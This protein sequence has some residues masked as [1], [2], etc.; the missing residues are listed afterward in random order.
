MLRSSTL[1]KHHRVSPVKC[2]PEIANSLSESGHL[3][4]LCRS[5]LQVN[6]AN[7]TQRQEPG[8]RGLIIMEHF[9]VISCG[10]AQ[11]GV[12]IITL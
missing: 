7:T 5:P 2:Q 1:E 4:L 3:A 9:L 6:D 10:N 12:K 8:E 11:F